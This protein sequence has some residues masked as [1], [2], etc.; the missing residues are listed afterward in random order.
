MPFEARVARFLSFAATP[1]AHETMPAAPIANGVWTSRRS[2]GSARGK[3][4]GLVHM[5]S[6]EASQGDYSATKD[7]AQ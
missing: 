3:K 4:I 7:R 2:G 6:S 1:I 5:F